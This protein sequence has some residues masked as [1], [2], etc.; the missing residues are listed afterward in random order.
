MDF[1]QVRYFLVL[2][3]TLNFT[4]AAEQ[5]YVSQP[6]LTQAIKRLE[7]ELGGKLFNRG[8]QKVTITNLGAMLRI[9]FQQI[10]NS[11][12]L[13]NATSKA[14]ASG[15]IDKLNI[16]IMCTIGPRVLARLLKTFQSQFPMVSFVIFDVR[17]EEIPNLLLTGE[18][19]G[20]FCA[21][22][23]T[24]HP[25]LRYIDL[26]EEPMVV[27]FP[28]DHEFSTMN[29]VPLRAIAEQPY[30]DRTH[31]EFRQSFMD[32]CADQTI[33]L[34]V[35]Y[36]S[37]REDWIQSLVRDGMGVTVIPRF[38]LLSPEL[39]HRRI[40]EPKLTRR[41]AFSLSTQQTI[42]PAMDMFIKLLE[43]YDWDSEIYH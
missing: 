37:Q 43:N 27:A 17:P 18:L 19:N 5:C 36:S 41:V 22:H 25:Q 4:R 7:H 16:G 33:Q 12:R 35:A 31:C 28:A 32:Y 42:P 34:D 3:E 21:H 30:I 10:D 20:A 13:V 6:A 26:F 38:S 24:S 2:A 8:G 9:H 1:N 39:D 29:A 23:L 40:I 15:E 11:K 14:V